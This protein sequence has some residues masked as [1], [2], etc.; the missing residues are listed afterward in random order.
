M[1]LL[2]DEILV[3]RLDAEA[4][5]VG[6]GHKA[7]LDAEG[8]LDE[9]LPPRDV[10]GVDF[11]RH[12]VARRGGD[13]HGGH[14][15]DG[16]LGHV[17]RH[18]DAAVLGV[19]ADLLRLGDAAG[20]QQVGVDDGERARVEER[21]EVLEEVD[22]LARAKR[23]GRGGVELAPHL[24]LLPRKRV[25]HPREVVLLQAAGEADAVLQRDVAEVV[26]GERDFVAHLLATLAEVPLEEVEALLGDV[27]A[28]EPVLGVEEV[29][30]FAA[31]GARVDGAVRRLDDVLHLLHEVEVAE[32]R[33]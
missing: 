17:D 6:D 8:R 2:A 22:V 31:H 21:L 11:E 16:R 12:E 20:G 13:V 27:D 15:R 18:L 25:L 19:V 7:V 3:E 24:R 32:R 33:G 9:V 10:D 30:G 14:R 4:G 1:E 5:R 29:V 28:G 23:D 26:D